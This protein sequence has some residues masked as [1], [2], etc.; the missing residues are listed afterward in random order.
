MDLQDFQPQTMYFEEPLEDR[1]AALIELASVSYGEG[2][3]EQPLL[4]ARAL[5]PAS[6]T[7]MVALY[8][9]YYY[10]HRLDDALQVA[11][12]VM[13]EVG[14]AIGFP[15][16]WQMITENHLINGLVESFITVRF[17]LLA[18]KGAAF[19]QL[20]MG[21][22]AEAVAMLNKVVEFDSKDRLGARTLLQ[23]A[24][25]T[26]VADQTAAEQVA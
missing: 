2:D 24:G 3:A 22:R 11:H 6:L 23:M 5:A 16:H 7:V 10:Q 26:L 25:P 1:V 9:F 21:R 17:Y 20:R 19:L 13:A 4:Q 18:L 14:Q 12:D 8:R 15:E